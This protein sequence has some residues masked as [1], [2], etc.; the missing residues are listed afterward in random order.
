MSVQSNSLFKDV[1][2][3]LIALLQHEFK[4]DVASFYFGDIGDYPPNAFIGPD[5]TYQPVIAISPSYNHVEEG[6]Q[7]FGGEMRLLGID[8]LVLY[9][10]TSQIEASPTQATGEADLLTIV[11]K[12]FEYLRR[13]D[14]L[15]LFDNVKYAQV[16]DVNWAWTP[17]QTSPIRGAV[18]SYEV[19]VA[20]DHN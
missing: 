15:T 14:M 17:R 19:K 1:I 2:L 12:I 10:F 3:T 6:E 18:I 11:D 16:G 8:I 20:I 4:H 7:W 13:Y 9:N 5:G